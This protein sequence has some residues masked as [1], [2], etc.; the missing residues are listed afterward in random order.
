MVS[1]GRKITAAGLVERA[2]QQVAQSLH[3]QRSWAWVMVRFLPTT[4]SNLG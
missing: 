3:G 4:S 2:G 1:N